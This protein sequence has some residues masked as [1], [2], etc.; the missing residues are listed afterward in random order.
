MKFFGLCV[1]VFFAIG[2][3]CLSNV[4]GLDCSTIDGMCYSN[5][6]SCCEVTNC[7]CCNEGAGCDQ[8]MD[9][10]FVYQSNYQCIS[11][12]ELFGNTCLFCENDIDGYA[13]VFDGICGLWHCIADDYVT[14]DGQDDPISEDYQ[15]FG[16]GLTAAINMYGLDSSYFSGY[17]SYALNFAKLT[18]YSID[19]SDNYEEIKMRYECF[20]LNDVFVKDAND[21][22]LDAIEN[23]DGIIEDDDGEE[24]NI[25]DA[26]EAANW[27]IGDDV[28][29]HSQF[30]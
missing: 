13:R 16:E 2:P 1:V 26:L 25:T 30:R 5:P 8:C 23:N 3:F 22:I 4:F 24:Y 6:C 21:E 17:M 20:M 28:Y 11:C 29:Q 7:A 9:G 10:Y 19:G 15:R 14:E 18:D 12:S 27:T